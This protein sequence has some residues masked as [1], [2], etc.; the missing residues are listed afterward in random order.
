MVLVDHGTECGASW[1]AHLYEVASSRWFAGYQRLGAA[2]LQPYF[3]N[4]HCSMAGDDTQPSSPTAVPWRAPRRY[5]PVERVGDP[6]PGTHQPTSEEAAAGKAAAAAAAAAMTNIAAAA[7]AAPSAS[8]VVRSGRP[9]PRALGNGRLSAFDSPFVTLPSPSYSIPSSG[10]RKAGTGARSALA[11]AAMSQRDMRL[12]TQLDLATQGSF[13]AGPLT[14]VRCAED[15][16]PL[17]G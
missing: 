9:A 1:S 15:P 2:T 17:Q 3:V 6:A 16:R 5:Q 14:Q 4:L 7:A 10:V 11:A 12:P 13:A 8:A